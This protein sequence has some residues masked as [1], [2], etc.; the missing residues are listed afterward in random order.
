MRNAAKRSKRYIYNNRYTGEMKVL[1]K[2]QGKQLN[3]DW[4]K[5]QPAVNEKGEHVLRIQ[6]AGGTIDISENKAPAEDDQDGKQSAE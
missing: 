5:V 3:E 6:M 1:T 4:S 2:G